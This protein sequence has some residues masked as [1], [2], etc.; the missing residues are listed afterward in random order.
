MRVLA[1]YGSSMQSP[2]VWRGAS[3]TSHVTLPSA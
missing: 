1:T 2:A 3:S